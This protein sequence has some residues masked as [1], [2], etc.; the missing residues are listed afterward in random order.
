MK[1]EELKKL[2]LEY[3]DITNKL[4]FK[5]SEDFYDEQFINLLYVNTEIADKITV[6]EYQNL[7]YYCI[8]LAFG[9]E[10]EP[11]VIVKKYFFGY[12]KQKNII[13]FINQIIEK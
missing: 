9:N 7:I 12:L 3:R 6:K 2:F 13:N 1:I 5:L 10:I 4:N 8:G 11:P